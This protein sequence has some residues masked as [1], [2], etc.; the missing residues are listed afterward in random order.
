MN[1]KSILI[2]TGVVG[3]VAAL[4]GIV[5]AVLNSKQ[6]RMVRAA[7]R[8]GKILYKVGTVLQNLSGMTDV[9]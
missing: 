1:K 8:T 3:G 6:M 4:G 5:A 9:L 7:R 2:L